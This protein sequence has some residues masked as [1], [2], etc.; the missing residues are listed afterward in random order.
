MSRNIRIVIIGNGFGGVYTLRNLHKS[1]HRGKKSA[2][3]NLIL[4]GKKNYFLFTPLLHEVAT[5]SVSPGNI[6]EPI[7]K[8]LGCCLDEFYLGPAGRVNTKGKTVAVGECLVPYDYLVI[9]TGAE[10]NFYDVPGAEEYTFT[11]KSLED[12]VRIK[13]HIIRQVEKA[14]YET[15]T[16]LRQKMLS[17]V[18]AGGGATGVE[19]A[20]ELCELVKGSFPRYYR[21]EITKD[22]SVTLIQKGPELLP[23]FHFKIREKSLEILKRKGVRVILNGEITEVGKSYVLVRNH[24]KIE[25]ESVFWMAGIKPAEM[26]FDREVSRWRDG[27]LM[28]DEYLRL[29]GYRDIFVLGDTAA[30][31]L[32]GGNTFLPALAQVTEKEAKCVAQNIYLPV[33]GRASDTNSAIAE[34]VSSENFKLKPFRYRHTGHLISLG[35]WRAVGEIAGF[36]FSGRITWWLWRTLYLSKMISFRKKVK[37]A[38]DW[39]VN[40]F[41]PRDISEL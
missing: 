40:L 31:K 6:V 29:A 35:Q 17:F 8:I 23:Q 19:L 28:T 33:S 37:V 20:A 30:F 7:R 14:S 26:N 41:S 38:I 25:T 22:A 10:T 36:I 4:I 32:G 9:A 13:N 2:G 3:V 15:D 39:T 34:S 27:R 5:G 18:V 24:G 16:G 12:A 11:L 1:L 21:K